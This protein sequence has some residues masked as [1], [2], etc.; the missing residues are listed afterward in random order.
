MPVMNGFDCTLKIREIEKSQGLTKDKQSYIVGLSAHSN[1][2]N[3]EK[4]IETGMDLFSKSL[5]MI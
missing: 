3:R 4:C 2:Y 5:N 1:D